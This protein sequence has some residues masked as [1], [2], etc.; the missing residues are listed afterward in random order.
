[1]AP[2]DEAHMSSYLLPIVT[3]YTRYI[4]SEI[5][6]DIGWKSQ[7]FVLRFYVA[8]SCGKTAANMFPLF[9]ITTKPD[10]WPSM[11]CN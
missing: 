10:P 4:I 8:T 1:M 9:F 6:W 3:G 11:W 5:K 7:F 2:F